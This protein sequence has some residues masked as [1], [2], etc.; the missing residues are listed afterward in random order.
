MNEQKQPMS[1]TG[2]SIV[3]A[4]AVF[5]IGTIGGAQWRLCLTTSP[6]DLMM[7]WLAR[8]PALSLL[9]S[10]ASLYL[11]GYWLSGSRTKPRAL[12]Q[13]LKSEGEYERVCHSSLR[14]C[15][16]RCNGSLRPSYQAPQPVDPNEPHPH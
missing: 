8:C 7:N 11:C 2:R 9:P 13:R 3:S 16:R 14:S 1:L 12:H 15:S 10:L 5:A 6:I 4:L